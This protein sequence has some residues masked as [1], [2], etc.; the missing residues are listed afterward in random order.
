MPR[1]RWISTLLALGLCAPPCGAQTD[2]AQ[3]RSPVVE[4]YTL[5]E[6]LLLAKRNNAPLEAA[7]KSITIAE[8][9]V[10]EAMTRFVPEVGL[11]ALATRYRARYPFSLGPEF[12]S[13]L[14]F[15]SS[16]DNLFSGQAYLTMPVYEGRRTINTLQLARRA[17]KQANSDYEA[18]KLDVVYETK[19]VFYRLILAQESLAAVRE[20]A[21]LARGRPRSRE[22]DPLRRLEAEALSADLRSAESDAGRELELARLAFLR[23][24][25][26]ELDSPVQLQGRL[27]TSPVE[28]DLNKALVWA[29]ELRPEL[30]SQIYK[31]QMDAISV[32]LELGRRY[33][34]VVLG[35]D[36]EVVG[37]E[38][39]LRQNNWDATVGV[40]LPF[41][42]DFWTRH[43]QKVA[44]QRQ[45][46]VILADLRDTVHL[47]VRSAYKDLLYWQGE[48]PRREKEY[49]DLKD[50]LD[51]ALRERSSGDTLRA[52]VR[53]LEARRRYLEA[54]AGHILARARLERA[55][56]KDL[57][58]PS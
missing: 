12:R 57:L 29:T 42:T 21:D 8:E 39:P 11:Q 44:E 48:W 52:A 6:A 55:V 36:Y 17:L 9:R 13:G 35:L 25:N 14:L 19:K 47:E 50:L 31:A 15:P 3:A 51:A 22:A 1:P 58:A 56:G 5:E 30:H 4:S 49:R 45:G 27:E 24:L 43:N 2:D 16:Q 40:R 41:S 46:E 34:T 38:F 32:N 10:T 37:Q 54:V 33:P 28:L 23:G 18:V 26:R 53:V 20:L 7:E